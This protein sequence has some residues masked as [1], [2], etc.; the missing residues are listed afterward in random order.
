MS[1]KCRQGAEGWQ[2]RGLGHWT[3]PGGLGRMRAI[4]DIDVL[5]S[6]KSSPYPEQGLLLSPAQG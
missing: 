2:E 4:L 1:G 5:S 6:P 3:G